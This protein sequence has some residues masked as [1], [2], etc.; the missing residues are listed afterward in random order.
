VAH[1]SRVRLDRAALSLLRLRYPFSPWHSSSPNSTRPYRKQLADLVTGLGPQTVV[2]VGCGLGGILSRI[3]AKTRIGYDAEAA[4]IA[5]ALFLHGRSIEFHVGSFDEVRR[6]PIDVLIAVNWLHD[7]APDQ[8]RN[9]IEPLVSNVRYLLVDRIKP[10]A[11]S[12]YRYSHDFAFLRARARSIE[13]NGLD[14]PD[15]EF[16]LWEI[17]PPGTS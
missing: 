2:E 1:A 6:S 11:R 17:I 8:V 12:D 15:R 5:A 10:N 14:E 9:W 16:I 7:F 3:K 13:F 4:A